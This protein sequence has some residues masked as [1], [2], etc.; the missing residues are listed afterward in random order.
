V[1]T[2]FAALVVALHA[3]SCA[4]STPQ[5]RIASEPALY[6]ALPASQKSLVERGEIARGMSRDAVWIAWGAPT[7]RFEGSEEGRTTERW[8]YV[9]A[10]PVYH[11]SVYGAFGFGYGRYGRRG[12][13]YS[14]YAL[15]PEVTYLP[16]RRASVWFV[17]DQVDR[18]DRLR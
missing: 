12:Y 18:W 10:Q 8:D 17:N 14:A 5:S 6:Q 13:P 1:K 11:T 2:I 7:R 3:V 15:A 16:F 9:G 4:P